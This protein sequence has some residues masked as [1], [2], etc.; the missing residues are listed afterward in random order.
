[1]SFEELIMCK[2]KYPS[3]YSKLNGGYCVYYPS[4]IFRNTRD[5]PVCHMPVKSEVNNRLPRSQRLSIHFETFEQAP[6]Q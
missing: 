3:I 6:F 4:N 2:D 5:L 1:V